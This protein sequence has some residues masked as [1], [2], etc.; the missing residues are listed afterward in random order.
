MVSPAQIPKFS[1]CAISSEIAA[2][3]LKDLVFVVEVYAWRKR[4]SGGDFQ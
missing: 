3:G 2:S 1:G 4:R